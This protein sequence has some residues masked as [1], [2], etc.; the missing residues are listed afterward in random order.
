MDYAKKHPSEM[1]LGSP[2]IGS[3]PHLCIELLMKETGIK[4]THVPFPSATAATM[5]ML[6]GHV[7]FYIGSFGT[8]S[9]HIR[10]GKARGLIVFDEQR[11]PQF[12]EIPC[13]EEKGIKLD[14]GSGH[15]L[16]AKKGT[17]KPI[18][19]F[20]ANL[21]KQLANDSIV[22]S[23]LIRVGFVPKYRDPE[24]TEKYIM[25]KDYGVATTVFQK[26]GK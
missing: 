8:L 15:A 17:P 23:N 5:A 2:G 24:E 20:L 26:L 14:R 3:S 4:I 7:T 22:K 21:F 16:I 11:Y 9:S 12:P 13:I 1:T 10:D 18:L 25:T 6:G 19:D